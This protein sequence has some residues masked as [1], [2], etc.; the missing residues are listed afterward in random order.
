MT[1][2]EKGATD[3]GTMGRAYAASLFEAQ[4]I[5]NLAT[6]AGKTYG[7]GAVVITHG[8]ADAGNTD[9]ENELAQMQSDYNADLQ[10][11]PARRSRF[12]C[13]CRSRSRSPRGMG[14]SAVSTLAEWQVGLDHPGAVVCTGPK[15]QYSY[16]SDG[17]H[18][19]RTGTTAW[20]KS[21]ARSSSSRW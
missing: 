19:T 1:E 4:A 3:D 13:S 17:I 9:Y 20:A 15:Y 10:G 11:S 14:M 18:L 12:C 8:E 6:T 21:T 7:V 2:I 16:A 5:E